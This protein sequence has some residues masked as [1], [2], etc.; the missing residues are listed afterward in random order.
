M[1][2]F[3]VVGCGITGSTIANLLSKNYSIEIYDKA[4]GLGGR[5]SNRRF[6]KKAS[7][8]HGLQYFSPKKINF[9]NLILFLKKKN[10]IKEWKGN[11]INFTLSKKNSIKYIGTKNNN[12]IC[13]YLTKNIKINYLSSITHIKYQS[14]YWTVTVNNKYKKK[15]K[16]L[17][18]TC[19][20]PQVKSLCSKYLGNKIKSLEVKM[21]PNITVMAAYN[22]YKNLPISSIVFDDEIL[23]WASNENSKQRFNSDLS[24]W[25]IQSNIKFAK[26]FINKFKKNKKQTIQIILKKFQKLAGLSYKNITFSSIHG[27]KYAYAYKNLKMNSLWSNKYKIGVCGDWFLG[28]K[29]E[30]AI[31][32]ANDLFLKI[33]KKKPT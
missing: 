21:E 8:E 33:N 4:K 23:G 7:F 27:W 1:K 20:F 10:I 29:A 3:C 24:L 9:T 5:S 19:P 16:N 22:D 6:K 32:S 26:K 2:D 12:D 14:K 25:T 17:I 28:P 31:I 11:H 18:V 13:R 15:F 30:D